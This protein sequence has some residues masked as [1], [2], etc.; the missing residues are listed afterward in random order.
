MGDWDELEFES[1][2]VCPNCGKRTD[3]ETI[4][5]YCGAHL[6]GDDELQ[7]FHEEEDL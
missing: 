5:P 2:E 1:E 7:G 3:G 4:C 6:S